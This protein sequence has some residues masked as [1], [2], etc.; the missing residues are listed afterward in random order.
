VSNNAQ[1]N[2]L[3]QSSVSQ[4]KLYLLCKL[5]AGVKWRPNTFMYIYT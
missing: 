5:A 1:L 3:K 4:S 2:I